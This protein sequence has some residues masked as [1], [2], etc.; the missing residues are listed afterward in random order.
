MLQKINDADY[1]A[2]KLKFVN[3]WGE[4]GKHQR[5]EHNGINVRKLLHD[6]SGFKTTFTFRDNDDSGSPNARQ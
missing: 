3:H 6:L 5:G 1:L 4:F 2:L